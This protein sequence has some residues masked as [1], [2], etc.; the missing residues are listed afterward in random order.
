M[1]I[2]ISRAGMSIIYRC[3]NAKYNWFKKCP[4]RNTRKCFK[5]EYCKAEM[6][7]R[8]ASRLLD[9]YESKQGRRKSYDNE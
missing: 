1:V 9:S 2:A 8:D 7:A 6:A 4:D 3:V 5:C